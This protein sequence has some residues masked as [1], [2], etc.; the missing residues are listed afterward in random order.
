MGRAM[1]IRG[2]REEG[3][4]KKENEVYKMKTEMNLRM[5]TENVNLVQSTQDILFAIASLDNRK[6]L[7]EFVAD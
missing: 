3:D 5:L 7:G 4:W 1:N 6:R 2:F